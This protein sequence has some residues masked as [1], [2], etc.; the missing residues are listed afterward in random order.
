[1]KI[2]SSL[3]FFSRFQILGLCQLMIHFCFNNG[4][5]R[6]VFLLSYLF[7]FHGVLLATTFT[8]TTNVDSQASGTLRNALYN[9]V[10]GDTINFNSALGT[11][12]IGSGTYPTALPY[13]TGV[14][15]N[16]NNNT[17]SGTNTYPIFFA[18]TG[19]NSVSN[20][21]LTNGL[22]AGGNGGNAYH[23]SGTTYGGG[24]TGGGGLGAGGALFIC[25][26]AVVISSGVSFVSNSVSGGNAGVFSGSSGTTA[27][28]GGGGGLF[29]SNGGN[30]TGTNF[31]GAGGGGVFNSSG[32]AAVWNSAGGGGGVYGSNGGSGLSVSGGNRGGG[33][34]GGF[35]F[36][37]GGDT[38]AFNP[39]GGG[40]GG[41]VFFSYGGSTL[42][43]GLSGF[44]GA[45]G[46]GDNSANGGRPSGASFSGGGGGGGTGSGNNGGNASNNTGGTGG[47]PAGGITGG[48]AGGNGFLS[49]APSAGIPGTAGGTTSGGGG[50][51]GSSVSSSSTFAAGAGGG[52]GNAVVGGG[53]GGGVSVST[54]T[55]NTGAGGT[56]GNSSQQG[57]GGGGGC[58]SN[59]F[60]THTAGNG[61]NGGS[62]NIGGGGGGGERQ[63]SGLGQAGTGGLSSLLGGGGG[64]GD[65]YSGDAGNSSSRGGN[66]GNAYIGGGGGGGACIQNFG[67]SP[68]VGGFGG[69]S[70]IGG[71]GG[72]GAPGCIGGTPGAGGTGGFGGGNGGTVDVLGNGGSALGGAVFICTGG[73]LL[74]TNGTFAG[75]SLGVAGTGNSSGIAQGSEMYLMGGSSASFSVSVPQTISGTIAGSGGLTSLGTSVLTL[76]GTNTYFGTTTISS[77]TLK[78]TA[79]TSGLGGN[80]V[81]S[82]VLLFAQTNNST[83]SNVI[84][85]TGAVTQNGSA[86]LT[87]T[88][89]NT[90]SGS[91][92]ITTG[93]LQVGTANAFPPN[94]IVIMGNNSGAVLNFNN[95]SQTIS[96][97]SGGGSAGGTVSLGTGALTINGSNINTTYSGVITGTGG[98]TIQGTG[99]FQL[100]GNNTY[101]GTTTINSGTLQEG[102]SNALLP[103]SVIVIANTSGAG[104]DLNGFNQTIS[105]LSGGGSSGG[106]IA[107]GTGTLTIAGNNITTTYS[108]AIT[109][110]GGL[111]IQGTGT[112]RLGGTNNTYRGT[113]TVNRGT[114]QGGA[115]NAF[116]SNSVV[117]LANVAGASLDLNGF[118]QSVGSLSGG[119]S[120]GGNVSLGTGTLTISGSNINT[121]YAG[122]ITGTGGLT[123][124]GTGTFQLAGTNNT[125]LGTTT[126]NR[127][128][129]QGGAA[130]TLPINSIVVLPNFAG[131]GL[132]L[133]GFNQSV[134]SLSGGGSLGGNVALGAGTLTIAGSNIN[135]TYSGAITGSGG[136]TIQ[137]TGV[138]QLAGTNNTY[139]GTTTINRGTLQGGAANTLPINSIVVLPNFAGA[140]L[141]LNG[142]NQSIGSLSGGG[143]LGGNVALGTGTLTIAGSNISTTYSGAITGAG[144]LTIQGTGT[145]K[146]SGTHNTYSGTTTV[147]RG[148]LQAGVSNSFP[149]NSIVVMANAAGAGLDLNNFDASLGALSGGGSLGGTVFLGTG[150]LTLA[151]SNINT[152]YFGI[153]TGTG[154]LT[155]QGTGTFQLAGTN[156]TYFGTTTINRGTLQGGAVDVFPL[157]STVVM[158]NAAGAGLDLNGFNQTIGS[159]SGGGVLG[160]NV[161]LGTGTLTIGGSNI[162]TTYSGA[163]TG[164]GGLTLQGTGVFSLGGSN[165]TYTGTT[166]VNS[167]TLRAGVINAFSANSIVVMGNNPTAFLDLNN[168]NT[169]LASLSGGGSLGGTVSLGTGTLTLD[170]SN[171]NTI[172]SGIITGTGGLTIQGTGTFQ[173][174]GT[175]NTYLGTTTI[176]RGTLQ[177]GAVNALSLNSTVVMANAPGAGLDLNGFDQIISSLSGGGVWGG[178]VALGSGTLTIDGNNINAT[179]SGAITGAGGLTLEGTGI[180]RLGG[181][182][183]TYGGTTT[184]NGGTLQAVVANALP[185]N[186]TVVMANVSGA[187]LDLNN[188]NQSI[189]SLSGGGTLGGN[190]TLGNAILTLGGNNANTTYSGSISGTGGITKMGTG[191]FTLAGANNTYLGT[192]TIDQGTLRAG[193]VNTLPLNSTILMANVSGAILDLNSYNQSIG[194]L[195]GGGSLG[196]DVTLGNGTLTLGGNNASTSYAGSISGTG[197]ITKIGSGTFQLAGINNTYLGTTTVSGGTLQAG[198]INSL[199]LNSTV[200][201]ANAAGVTLDLNNFN[202][203]IG[204]LLGGGTAGGNVT[205]GNATLTLGGNNADTLYAGS[206]SGTGGITKIGTGIFLLAGANNTY[207]GTTTINGGILEAGAVNALPLNSPVIMGNTSGVALNLNN[208]DQVIGSLAGGGSA[209]GNVI[210]GSATL[211]LGGNNTS[212]LYSGVISGAGGISKVGG[213]TLTLGGKNTYSGTTTITSGQLIF[214][215]D[216]SSLVGTIID[217]SILTFNQTINTSFPGKIINS[218]PNPTINILGSGLV[219]FT[220]NSSTFSGTINVSGNLAVNG[221]LGNGSSYTIVTSGGKLSGT[222]YL[223]NVIIDSGGTISPGNSIGTIH[224]VSYTNNGGT[225]DVEINAAGQSDLIEVSGNATINGGLVVLTAINGAYE[226]DHAYTIVHA[227]NVIGQYSGIV[228]ALVPGN[229][230]LVKPILTYDPQHV[231]IGFQTYISG[232]ATTCNELAVASQLDGMNNSFVAQTAFINTLINL[233]VADARNVLNELSGQQY[234]DDLFI[235]ENINRQFIRRLYDPIRATVT[236][237]HQIPCRWDPFWG[238]LDVYKDIDG[239]LEFGSGQSHFNDNNRDHRLNIHNYEVTAGVQKRFGGDRKNCPDWTF[240]VAGS[241]ECDRFH[242]EHNGYGRTNTFLLGLY[243]LYRPSLC[244]G[245]IDLAAGHSSTQFSRF[246]NIGSSHYKMRSQPEIGKLT[247]YGEV[248][249]DWINRWFMIQPFA[250]L[251]LGNYWRQRIVEHSVGGGGEW[252]LI[253]DKRNCKSIYSRLGVHLTA[254]QL[255]SNFSVS[256]DLAW[257][258][259]LTPP[260]NSIQERFASFGD[261]F[262]IYGVSQDWNSLDYALAI[263]TNVRSGWRIYVEGIGEV[264]NH[265]STY[266]VQLGIEKSW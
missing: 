1:M 96:S 241:Y 152:T 177:S 248:G 5:F 124:Q 120:A 189:G 126:I 252:G 98:L 87:L 156:N 265:S 198:A 18:L 153:I 141:D 102:I 16:G 39:T 221:F 65:N 121:S 229:M 110:T 204:S 55:A 113:T 106:N 186:S 250:G 136:L 155:I 167:G 228:T 162:N 238:N 262:T 122:A 266:N 143:S 4:F 225:Y 145:L 25:P 49:A 93:T 223:G 60:N 23:S 19:T 74:I 191:V 11:I 94:A 58:S 97:L 135:T 45:G 174:A 91:T 179:Y 185:M 259:R 115:V 236:T 180:F 245:I 160:G 146:L 8:V 69:S 95:F 82:G 117:L 215:G 100:A 246:I 42:F 144:G 173:L 40:G 85:G 247:C 62:A 92:T 123:I 33:A 147:N 190:V 86:T 73:S 72:G 231:Y 264:W 148:T 71:G 208:F 15:I 13:L 114:F 210:L 75:N 41:G 47:S 195:L 257:N 48:G 211:T 51:G 206:I 149:A 200:F 108:G 127:G 233:P 220:G 3:P 34:G 9:A 218:V 64:G 216:T 140:G 53:G 105:S 197:G 10:S 32:G 255:P 44:G 99:T 203:A 2:T 6:Y 36:S 217:N 196:G 254:N 29:G 57:G 258:K 50:G 103:S 130:N 213:G 12:T 70:T 128:T 68:G 84:S 24:G 90:Y 28:G 178:N 168:F 212:T 163:I 150:T 133:N 112:F 207:L 256:V 26:G 214:T 31:A 239:W 166:T 35:Y 80:I 201:L 17:I 202:Q 43:N 139:L 230:L 234:A 30:V 111:T 263:S 165:N 244:Y 261:T 253:L 158:A 61:G 226:I 222:G 14:T 67:N 260:K 107:L 125:Y 20:L 243:S 142:F 187:T 205:L 21:T 175:N 52:G 170:G 242:Y 235:T 22:G 172:Y 89:T 161:T 101:L 79:D 232:V 188:F 59:S 137:G 193:A 184:V 194:S 66:G 240:G 181:T 164:V 81:N 104:L 56:G 199:P 134:G 227:S 176:N 129:L 209:G 154:G 171:I 54:S 131:A 192:T 88:G 249:V 251:E 27:G 183:N 151:G 38:G 63:S 169:S 116:S 76:A 119:G 83:Y 118:N 46:G 219:N 77:G 109:G 138:F 237:K 132:D 182:N 37:P 157:N 224:V 78:F 159:L 7:L